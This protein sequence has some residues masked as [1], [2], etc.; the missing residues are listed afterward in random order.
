M[1]KVVSNLTTATLGASKTRSDFSK[2]VYTPHIRRPESSAASGEVEGPEWAAILSARRV[3]RLQI[4][5]QLRK[6]YR[7][8]IRGH[9]LLAEL[10]PVYKAEGARGLLAP[11]NRDPYQSYA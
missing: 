7:N 6:L 9:A 10:A 5:V 2:T 4:L 11:R 3:R 8:L 1:S